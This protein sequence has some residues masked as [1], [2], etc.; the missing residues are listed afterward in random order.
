MSDIISVFSCSYPAV[1]NS[2]RQGHQKV[3]GWYLCV[4]QDH[5]YCW[6]IECWLYKKEIKRKTNCSICGLCFG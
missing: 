3:F 1:H 4:R 2:E 5:S 6:R